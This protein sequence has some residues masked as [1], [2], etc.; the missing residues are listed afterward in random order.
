MLKA[1][2]GKRTIRI[3]DSLKDAYIG[4]GY[5]VTDAEGN[6]VAATTNKVKSASKTAGKA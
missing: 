6:D 3:K 4:L 1:T 5:T 2:K